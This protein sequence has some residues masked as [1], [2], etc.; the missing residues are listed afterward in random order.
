MSTAT[1]F[2]SMT[3]TDG[4]PVS[5]RPDA[6]LAFTENKERK[7]GETVTVLTLHLDGG[8]VFNVEEDMDS[9][10]R[11]FTDAQGGKRPQLVV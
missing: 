4:L 3:R 6:I 1:F 7:K 5:V 10:W 9:F 8:V 11:K 2:I